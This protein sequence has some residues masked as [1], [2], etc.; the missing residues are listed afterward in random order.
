VPLCLLYEFAILAIWFT[1][2]R[3]AKQVPVA[4]EAPAE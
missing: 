2:K 4:T 3:R 1:E